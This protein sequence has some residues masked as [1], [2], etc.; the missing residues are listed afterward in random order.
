[1]LSSELYCK[2][3]CDTTNKSSAN[4]LLR[5]RNTYV[6]RGGISDESHPA[7]SMSDPSIPAIKDEVAEPP[8]KRPKRL[9]LADI[10]VKMTAQI[11]SYLPVDDLLDTKHT[12]RDWAE[13]C[14]SQ[15]IWGR[16]I[17]EHRQFK[18]IEDKFWDWV[19]RM[20]S[21]TV[22]TE[23]ALRIAA[24]TNIKSCPT[25]SQVCFSELRT[26][27]LTAVAGPRLEPAS[28]LFCELLSA[29]ASCAGLDDLSVSAVLS[30]ELL[31]S[32]LVLASSGCKL[33][34]LK[35]YLM[36]TGLMFYR[37]LAGGTHFD[38]TRERYD[39]LVSI[40]EL[41]QES[42][43]CLSIGVEYESD[44]PDR[45]MFGGRRIG[46]YPEQIRFIVALSKMNRLRELKYPF[47]PRIVGIA[48][49]SNVLESVEIVLTHVERSTSP[50]S[51]I[52][53]PLFQLNLLAELP[54]SVTNLT[55]DEYVLV[56]RPSADAARAYYLTH[57]IDWIM[58][59]KFV[60]LEVLDIA[61]RYV[62]LDTLD[63]LVEGFFQCF[64]NIKELI[65]VG[66]HRWGELIPALLRNCGKLQKLD[67][68]THDSEIVDTFARK[69]IDES[70]DLFKLVWG[71]N[72]RGTTLHFSE[73]A[74]AGAD[75]MEAFEE[76]DRSN[77]PNPSCSV[78]IIPW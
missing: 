57:I 2:R 76:F 28:G 44:Y 68:Y 23:L 11:L 15:V 45:D 50:D 74:K 8:P 29:S 40:F 16:V 55:I 9:L 35:L 7:R 6:D 66:V 13:A 58:Q 46:H 12:S 54:P 77:K 62:G 42:L 10:P 33:K 72:N 60:K 32:I 56:S 21:R 67:L 14:G 65:L 47:F 78:R 18:M 49:S 17:V 34:R 61:V 73:K 5:Y 36:E 39:R 48:F 63:F 41:H 38:I 70:T 53:D 52:E 24:E 30:D 43:E 75:L 3:E 37:K 71:G 25:Q 51:P 64:P 59:G 1:M 4:F 22:I 31:N 20:G 69:S 19:D 26:L 27:H